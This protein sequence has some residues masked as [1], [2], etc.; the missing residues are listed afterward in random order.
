[1]GDPAR[2]IDPDRF[3]WRSKLEGLGSD[4][5]VRSSGTA[6]PNHEH[7]TTEQEAVATWPSR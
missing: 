6:L 3:D 1:M 7:S 5:D 4:W 2:F